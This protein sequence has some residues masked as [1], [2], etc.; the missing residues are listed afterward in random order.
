M[1]KTKNTTL[2]EARQKAGMTQAELSKASGVGCSLITAIEQ[3]RTPGNL[4]DRQKLADALR[5]PFRV[6][7]PDSMKEIEETMNLLRR[8]R[9]REAEIK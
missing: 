2:K 9:K 1:K 8:D 7:W 4:L 5:L 3:G 6:I